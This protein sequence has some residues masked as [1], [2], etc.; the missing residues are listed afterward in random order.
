MGPRQLDGSNWF[1][2][3]KP[4]YHRHKSR[5]IRR[6][7]PISCPKP[8]RC[9]TRRW[10]HN[11]WYRPKSSPECW[12]FH[13]YPQCILWLTFFSREST[14]VAKCGNVTE[15]FTSLG[16]MIL[17][18]F[19]FF[20]VDFQNRFWMFSQS[21]RVTCFHVYVLPV[22]VHSWTFTVVIWDGTLTYYWWPIHL[23]NTQAT[24]SHLNELG[25]LL[26][27][28]SSLSIISLY[29]FCR[30]LICNDRTFWAQIIFPYDRIYPGKHD[31]CSFEVYQPF[32]RTICIH[33][34]SQA[35]P[36]CDCEPPDCF[37]KG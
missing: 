34:W 14:G 7:F 33:V 27:S 37:C 20:F 30:C 29:A 6:E 36:W 35:N 16:F 32:F 15:C 23:W 9:L 19:F 25:S 21:R 26:Q 18:C 2:H 17:V 28:W 5:S 4:Q 3:P 31:A 8:D 11:V 24:W 13:S 12:S 10:V 22:V 1:R